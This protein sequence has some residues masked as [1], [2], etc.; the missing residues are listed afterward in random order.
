MQRGKRHCQQTMNCAE[1]D[2]HTADLRRAHHR[3]GPCCQHHHSKHYP[4]NTKAFV[5]ADETAPLY[6]RPYSAL[7]QA[8]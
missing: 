8:G 3:I 4:N 1:L 7:I 2:H 5:L 6:S